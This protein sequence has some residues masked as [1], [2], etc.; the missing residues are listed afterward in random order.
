MQSDSFERLFEEHAERLFA[1]LAYRTGNRVLAEDLLSETFER[2][3]R[4]RRRFD[5]RRGSE[6]RWLYT[7]ALNLLRDHARR[8]VHENSLLQGVGAETPQSSDSGLDAV[9]S[10][11]EL[12]RA[13]ALLSDDEREAIALRFGADLKLREVAHVL[14]EGESAVEGRIYRGLRKLREELGE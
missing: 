9:G 5:P 8:Q 7:I 1:F 11:D 6:R 12:T 14:G 4:S 3:L 10:R 13:L 2:V